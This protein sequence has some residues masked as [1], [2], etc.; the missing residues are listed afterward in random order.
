MKIVK[1]LGIICMIALLMGSAYA[2]SDSQP[3]KKAVDEFQGEFLYSY[4][5]S[6]GSTRLQFYN[7]EE[8][9]FYSGYPVT[10]KQLDKL[11]TNDEYRYKMVT[12]P[13]GDQKISIHEI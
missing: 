1:I 3:Q 7:A 5:A 10:E 4:T 8:N 13:D 9:V 12:Q 2:A 6:D 11:V